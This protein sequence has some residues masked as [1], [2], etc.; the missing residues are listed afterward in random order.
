MINKDAGKALG[1]GEKARWLAFAH[2]R[3]CP[4]WNDHLRIPRFAQASASAGKFFRKTIPGPTLGI[5]D[6]RGPE[7]VRVLQS[8]P[9]P[10]EAPRFASSLSVPGETPGGSEKLCPHPESRSNSAT[11]VLMTLAHCSHWYPMLSLVQ[12]LQRECHWQT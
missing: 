8:S 4:T 10:A 5:S 2:R 9:V 3:G 7:S 12:S 1:M 6:S 11:D